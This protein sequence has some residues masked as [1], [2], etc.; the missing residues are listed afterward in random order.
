MDLFSTY[1]AESIIAVVVIVSIVLFFLLREVMVW[2]YKIGDI[3]AL[4]EKIAGVP[5]AEARRLHRVQQDK[6]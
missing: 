4:L 5:A 3:I 6:R 2:Y 1:P